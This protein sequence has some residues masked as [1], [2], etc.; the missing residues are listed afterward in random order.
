MAKIIKI[1]AQFTLHVDIECP[2][3]EHDFNLFDMSEL[4]DE[5]KIHD[6]LMPH[7]KPWMDAGKNFDEEINCPEC[8]KSILITDIH[9]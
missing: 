2:Y 6:I 4:T 5:G 7:Q 9:Y 3:C 8:K 1:T